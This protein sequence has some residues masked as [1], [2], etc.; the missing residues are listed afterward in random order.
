M[1]HG[2]PVARDLMT[3]SAQLVGE[4]LARI[5]NFVN[6]ALV[7]LGGAVPDSGDIY[8]TKVRQVVLSR[9]LPLATRQLR[10]ERSPRGT[11]P[12]LTG[13]AFMVVD[14]LFSRE[15]L[16]RWIRHQTPAGRP[17]LVS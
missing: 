8:L 2:D 14:E 3:T 10:L 12:A 9:S 5:V 4:T 11:H 17:E 16:G 7:V 13:G 15:R 6:P 1:D